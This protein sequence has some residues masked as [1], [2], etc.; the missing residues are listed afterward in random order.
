MGS[1][2]AP[3]C[4][5]SVLSP[6]CG[7]WGYFPGDCLRCRVSWGWSSLLGAGSSG[8]VPSLAVPV[9]PPAELTARAAAWAP[10]AFLGKAGCEGAAGGA[11]TFGLQLLSCR[12]EAQSRMKEQNKG[13]GPFLVRD[14]SNSA[15]AD[16][17]DQGITDH[18]YCMKIRGN[19]EHQSYSHVL[20]GRNI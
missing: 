6:G 5:G 15:V 20:P 1:L 4:M 10:I 19:Q 3:P 16:R 7:V 12:E 2:S 18:W 11:V 14:R 17:A 9:V 8:F 13:N